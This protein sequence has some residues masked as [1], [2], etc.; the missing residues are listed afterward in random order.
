MAQQFGGK[1]A[2]SNLSEFGYA[3][4]EVVEGGDLLHNLK[5]D[6]DENGR[7]QLDVWMSHGD[8]VLEL[9]LDFMLIASTNNCP[10]AG[11]QHREKPFYGIQFHPEV[12]HTLQG[13]SLLENFVVALS[14]C[15]RRWNTANIVEDTVN[16]IRA[17]VG[18]SLIHI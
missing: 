12:T 2:T 6:I 5:D 1:V 18:L 4:I 15:E 3:R 17:M 11:M 14:G 7:P 8:K 10:I 16:T 13:M 9:P